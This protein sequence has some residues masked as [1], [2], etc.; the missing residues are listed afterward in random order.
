MFFEFSEVFGEVF[1]DSFMIILIN[2]VSM[3]MMCN[4]LYLSHTVDV[5]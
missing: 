2:V 3:E 1:G 5:D 4:V